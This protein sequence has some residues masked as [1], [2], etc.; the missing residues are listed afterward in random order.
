MSSVQQSGAIVRSY[1][2][3]ALGERVLSTVPAITGNPDGSG[4]TPAVDTYSVYDESGRWLGDY[5]HNGVVLQQAIWLDDLPDGLLTGTGANQKLHYIEPDH[6]GTPRAVIDR[7]RDVAIWTWALQGEAFGNSA[8]NQDP[9]LDSIAFVLDMRFPGQRYDAATD[10]N[11]NYFRDY[12]PSSGRYVQGDPIGLRG[13]ISTYGYADGAPLSFVDPLGLQALAPLIVGGEKR[14]RNDVSRKQLEG[15]MAVGKLPDD[16]RRNLD[17]GCVG[18]VSAYQGKNRSLPEHAPNT[19]CYTSQDQATD[20]ATCRKPFIFAKQGYWRH[21]VPKPKADGQVPNDSV[22][23]KNDSGVF[24]YVVYFS[25]TSTYAWM[26][27]GIQ[28]GPQTAS[29]SL[30]PPS[31]YEYP[32]T[33]WCHTCP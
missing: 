13:G 27:H 11:Y 2:Y 20:A 5:D 29:L 1:A 19:K 7:T 28:E 32:Q 10:L 23:G 33:I 3:N 24:N 22:M 12:E 9:D 31:S 30:Y 15:M 8:P 26:D 18:L 17:R 6:L 4:G 25:S 21:G 16:V 14:V